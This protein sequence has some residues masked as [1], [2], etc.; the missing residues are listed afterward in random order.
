MKNIKRAFLATIFATL[1]YQVGISALEIP[2]GGKV[3][4]IKI[5]NDHP[6]R[7]IEITVKSR[8]GN[9]TLGISASEIKEGGM[10]DEFAEKLSETPFGKSLLPW[11][12][13]PQN[14]ASLLFS[15]IDKDKFNEKA[16]SLSDKE[17]R[18]LAESI[19][20]ARGD[21]GEL[22]GLFMAFGPLMDPEI[23]KSKGFK[24]KSNEELIN[25]MKKEITKIP[26]I[27][28]GKE[29]LEN[30]KKAFTDLGLV[31]DPGKLTKFAKALDK[32]KN[33]KTPQEIKELLEEN[34][35]SLPGLA[36]DS[37]DSDTTSNPEKTSDITSNPEETEESGPPS[38]DD[39]PS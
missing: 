17:R 13:E 10:Q 39:P 29:K 31:L 14:A 7:K 34:K 3:T 5:T 37:E 8:G 15:G 30:I 24:E 26:N 18:T 36:S 28:V 1:G 2:E 20:S 21:F 4:E 27:T 11:L 23:R 25:R 35:A 19:A 6:D 32:F 16:A 9:L 12:Y 38:D 33:R 22:I